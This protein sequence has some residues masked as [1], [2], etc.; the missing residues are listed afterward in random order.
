[1]VKNILILTIDCWNLNIAANSSYTYSTLFS[2]MNEYVLSNLY[3]REELPNDPCCS[4]YFQISE[5]KVI[6][7]ILNK[8]IK[9]GREVKCE[10]TLTE[11]ENLNLT[12]QKELYLKHRK[13]FYYTKKIIREFIWKLSRWKSK[14][15]NQFLENVQPDV[16][17]FSMEGYIH[18]NRI[19]RYVLKKTGAKS[20]GYF[21]DDNFTYKQRPY[22]IGYK[23]L[24]FFQ[25]KSL[26]KLVKNTTS[27]W[28]ISAKTKKEADQ[29]FGIDCVVLPKPA[30]HYNR[31]NLVSSFSPHKPLKMMY[32]GNLMIGRMD[33]IKIIAKVFSKINKEQNKICL[34]IYTS[35]EVPIDLQNFEKGLFFHKPISQS[36]VLELQQQADILLFVE[37]IIGKERKVARLSFSTKIPDYLSSGKCIFAIGDKDTAPMEYLNNESAAICASNID[38]IYTQIIKIIEN[39]NM[40]KDYGKK[41]YDCAIRNHQKAKIQTIVKKTIDGLFLE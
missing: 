29:F 41:A 28:A 13:K 4:R 8:K 23:F 10:G 31:I 34:D 30:E 2:S 32:A 33:T 11:E 38:E 17:I 20:I 3:I 18:F 9:T 26:K 37:D 24:R 21:W 6:K 40:L 25:R 36:K 27:F 7:S 12:Q 1:M 15:L 35:T 22:N 14:E 39:P 19:C 5:N 16:V